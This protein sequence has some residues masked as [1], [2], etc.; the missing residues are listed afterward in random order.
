M[1]VDGQTRHV[2]SITE[3]VDHLDPDTAV[4]VRRFHDKCLVFPRHLSLQLLPV[5]RQDEGPGV[6]VEMAAAPAVPHL[7]EA[8]PQTVLT[9]E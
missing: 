3:P 2:L 7:S 8:P 1:L 4:P 9:A 5:L 6:E